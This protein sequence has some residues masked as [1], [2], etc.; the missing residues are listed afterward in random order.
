MSAF[1]NRP[2]QRRLIEAPPPA[3]KSKVAIAT[4][5]D[6]TQA[7]RAIREVVDLLGGA[8][9]FAKPGD[10]V[11]IKPNMIAA[12]R[13]E[14]AEVTHPAVIEAV[15]RIFK[16]AGATVW[17]G[18]QTGWHGD[19]AATFEMTGMNAAA[20][21]GGADAI[22]NWEHEE[23]IDVDVPNGR[24]MSVVKLP[25]SLMEADVIVSLPKMKTNVV[26]MA[27]LGIKNWM[28]ALHNS[29]R[30]FFH[31]TSMD[32]IAMVDIV[33]ALGDRLKLN[34]LDGIAGMDGAGPHAGLVTYPGV[35]V[36][37]RDVVAFDA[38]GCAIMDI[39]PYEAPATQAAMK[40]GLGTGDL[41]EIE[42]LGK[43]IEE[44]R[45]PFQRPVVQVVNRYPNVMEFFGGVCSG[46]CLHAVNGLPPH[47]DPDKRYAIVTGA[48][49]M[50]GQDLSAFDEVWL[51]G[52][53]ACSPSHQ[54]PGFKDKLKAARKVFSV[55]YCPAHSYHLHYW[56]DPDVNASGDVYAAP[57]VLMADL[58]TF[59]QVPDV[60]DETKL[61]DAIARKEGRMSLDETMGNYAAYVG[62][63]IA[64]SMRPASWK[65]QS[66]TALGQADKE[67]P[68]PDRS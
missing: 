40:D 30:P 3:E 29:Q 62:E 47:V 19:P 59:G 32:I 58:V 31:K 41:R 11:L 17:V 45:H 39:H 66:I 42:V 27:S 54:L 23:Y 34:I 33:K 56:Q 38:V 2:S 15:V 60:T 55:N 21:A 22:C 52:M 67:W 9:S 43:T 36:A 26:Q 63:D 6:Y 1:V 65:A 24:F 49:A 68:A 18:E 10:V 16:E 53:C 25:K 13:A 20:R 61:E 51:A 64:K 50:I 28:G 14:E 12:S 57:M 48:R 5:A 44:V 46:P 37:S 7:E 8:A 4:A 35:V